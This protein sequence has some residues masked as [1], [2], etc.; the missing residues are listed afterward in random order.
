MLAAKI[1]SACSFTS[2]SMRA[3]KFADFVAI[4]NT[5]FEFFLTI[6]Y[7][8]VLTKTIQNQH[9]TYCYKLF[10]LQNLPVH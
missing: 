4:A 5:P 7:P 3:Y 9:F 8:F 6:L 2:G 1:P 10:V